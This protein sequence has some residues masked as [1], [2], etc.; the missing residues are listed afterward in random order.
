MPGEG[1]FD[2]LK[3]LRCRASLVPNPTSGCSTFQAM[4]RG[5]SQSTKP[6]IPRRT[7]V[8]VSPRIFISTSGDPACRASSPMICTLA[9]ILSSNL[10]NAKSQSGAANSRPY[11]HPSEPR[12]ER[13]DVP[14]TSRYEHNRI[15][16]DPRGPAVAMTM[17]RSDCAHRS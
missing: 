1:F 5:Q 10:K 7:R 3:T 9:M 12:M 6:S 8:A 11:A 15:S 17:A 14:S 13:S 2:H 4:Y 16:A